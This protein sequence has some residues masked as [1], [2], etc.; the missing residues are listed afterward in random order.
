MKG[1]P[2][3]RAGRVRGYPGFVS[4]ETDPSSRRP[5]GPARARAFWRRLLGR[6]GPAARAETYRS[7]ATYLSSGFGAVEATD[8]LPHGP[9]VLALRGAAER[10]EPLAEGLRT[11]PDVVTGAEVALVEAGEKSGRLGDMLGKVADLLDNAVAARRAAVR[12]AAYPFTVLHVALLLPTIPLV[13]VRHG[14]AAWLRVVLVGL[15][16]LWGVPLLLVS[17]YGALR[18]HPTWSRRICRIPFLGRA[19]HCSALSR[20]AWTFAAMND[21][22]ALHGESLDQAARAAELGW[23]RQEIRPATERAE[24][25]DPLPA[26]VA[27][28]HV[29]PPQMHDMIRTGAT[30]GSLVETMER[31]G[32]IYDEETRRATG[33]TVKALRAIVF[34]LAVVVTVG[35]VL[36][37]MLPQYR[38]INDLLK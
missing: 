16:L 37:V 12:A 24:R 7:L 8:R 6:P 34:G 4:P 5:S 26:S 9:L 36:A 23:L 30:T 25:G 20:F 21:S 31:A 2:W 10:R 22:G 11:L 15:L 3:C 27:G 38:M 1:V 14:P 29:L 35:A 19:L 17:L 18:D 33:R 32:T 13:A 28:A